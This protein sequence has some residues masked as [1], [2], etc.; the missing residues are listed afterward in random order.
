MKTFFLN[1][2]LG[3]RLK[4]LIAKSITSK[5]QI[6]PGFIATGAHH[7][8]VGFG[9]SPHRLSA[10]GAHGAHRHGGV[11]TAHLGDGSHHNTHGV[12]KCSGKYVDHVTLII[13]VCVCIYLFIYSFIYSF[14]YL[15]VYLFIYV[16]VC[17][18]ASIHTAYRA[19]NACI[20]ERGKHVVCIHW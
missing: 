18:H 1:I 5:S 2:L 13:Y 17:M 11:C 19:Y 3:K 4:N 10:H 12:C 20:Y 7:L 9:P 14:I 8:N 6:S 15:F 16:C